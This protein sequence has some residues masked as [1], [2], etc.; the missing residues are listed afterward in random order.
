MAPQRTNILRNYLL[1][2]AGI[3]VGAGATSATGS[4]LPL[5]MG[6]AVS[7]MCTASL[8]RAIA[9]GALKKSRR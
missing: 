4:M 6:A 9:G 3:V 8:V 2:I 7:L 1:G 5:A